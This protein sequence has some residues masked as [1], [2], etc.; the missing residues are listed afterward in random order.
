MGIGRRTN[1]ARWNRCTLQITVP[2]GSEDL[3]AKVGVPAIERRLPGPGPVDSATLGH[4]A[5]RHGLTI[6]GPTPT[7]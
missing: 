6:L 5:T 3:A 7:A 1:S 2:G 4:A